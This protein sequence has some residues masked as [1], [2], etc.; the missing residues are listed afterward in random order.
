VELQLVIGGDDQFI[1]ALIDTGF[2]GYIAVP[3]QSL[4]PISEPDGYLPCG[5]AEGSVI[6]APFYRGR[7]RL[8]DLNEFSIVVLALG[9]EFIVGRGVTDRLR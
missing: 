9:D 1:E 8:G 2:D 6:E 5:L 7:V 4:P 3:S